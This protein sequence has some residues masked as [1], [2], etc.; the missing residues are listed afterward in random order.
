MSLQLIDVT[1]GSFSLAFNVIGFI[2]GLRIALKYFKLKNEEMKWTYFFFGIAVF[3]LTFYWLPTSISFVAYLILNNHLPLELLFFLGP[4]F[5]PAIT[6][7]F[8]KAMC[9]LLGYKKRQ[10]VIISITIITSIIFEVIFIVLLTIDASLIIRLAGPVDVN[11]GDPINLYG[12]ALLIVV[13]IFGLTLSIKSI[14]SPEPEINLRGKFLLVAFLSFAVGT[15]LDMIS[16]VSIVILTIARIILISG[17][18]LFYIGLVPPKGIKRFY[19][20]K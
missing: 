1:N 14:K 16:S 3:G 20:K 7:I 18:I 15:A 12:G 8:M 13:T 19:L 9:N 10:I 6:V 4:S 5:V 17:A 11:Y 2:I